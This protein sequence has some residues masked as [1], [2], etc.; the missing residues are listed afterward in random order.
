M[1]WPVERQQVAPIFEHRLGFGLTL[2]DLLGAA[3]TDEDE[4][5]LH[6]VLRIGHNDAVGPLLLRRRHLRM[7]AKTGSLGLRVR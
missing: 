7:I 5:P 4:V 6:L 1:T 3:R 2:L